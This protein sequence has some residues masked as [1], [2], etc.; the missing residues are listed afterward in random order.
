M[1][2]EERADKYQMCLASSFMDFPDI[3][4]AGREGYIQGATE[5]RERCIKIAKTYICSVCDELQYCQTE[6]MRIKQLRK[7]LE[8]G[9]SGVHVEKYSH[10]KDLF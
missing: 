9:N 2:I 7:A 3:L 10:V 8:G 1:T 6:C 4:N 5:E